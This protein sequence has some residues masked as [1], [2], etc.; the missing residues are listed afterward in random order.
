L[1]DI[2]AVGHQLDAMPEFFTQVCAQ[3]IAREEPNVW[4]ADV[5]A[6]KNGK[7]SLCNPKWE[8]TPDT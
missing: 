7:A 6:R 4:R 5:L 2:E 8:S 1:V 3:K